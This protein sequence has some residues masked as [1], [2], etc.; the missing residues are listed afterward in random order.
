[1]YHIVLNILK[2]VSKRGLTFD[3]KRYNTSCTFKSIIFLFI[4]SF[5]LQETIFVISKSQPNNNP[6]LV[7]PNRNLLLLLSFV[8]F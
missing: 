3:K 7:F 5:I 8:L 2:V 4:V 6:C 1:M